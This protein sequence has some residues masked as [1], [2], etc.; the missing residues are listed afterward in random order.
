MNDWQVNVMKYLEN[1]P[2]TA[3]FLGLFLFSCLFAY[4]NLTIKAVFVI[5][6]VL[7]IMLTALKVIRLR[8]SLRVLTI[9]VMSTVIISGVI[10]ALCFDIIG[11]VCENTV[12][13]TETAVI[14]IEEVEYAVSYEACY[15]AKIRKSDSIPRGTGLLLVSDKTALAEGTVLA[16]EVSYSEIE[17]LGRFDAERYYLSKN[18][19]LRA[20]DVSLEPA[21]E[22]RSFSLTRLFAKINESLTAKISAHVRYDAAGIASA[23]LLGN[24]DELADSTV[25]DFRRLGISHLLVVSGT[26][27]AVI[28]TFAERAM[29]YLLVKRKAR[30]W[31]NIAIVILFMFLTGFTPSV[32]R[33]GIMHI[34]A[35]LAN[36]ILRKKNMIHSFAVSG[37]VLVIA[38]PCSAVDCGMQLSFIATYVCIFFQQNHGF[39][40]RWLRKTKLKLRTIPG[41][42]VLSLGETVMLTSL[43][44]LNTLPLMWLYFGEISLISVPVNVVFIPVIT[45]LMYLTG[46]YLLLYPLMIFVQPMA[47]VLSGYCIF[48]EWLA[49]IFSRLDWIILPVNFSFSGLFLIPLTVLLVLLP[50]MG[51][52]PR[53]SI[54]AA[55]AVLFVSFVSAIGLA[56]VLDS[57]NNHFSYLPDK[58]N[59]GFALKSG[60]KVLLC[61][62]S[63]AS[64]SYMYNLTDEMSQLHASEIEALMLTHYHSKHVGLIEKL[65]QRE[66]LRSV[67]LPEPIDEREEGI[68]SSILESAELF[69]VNTVTI[70]AG[71]SYVFGDA[72]IT[73]FERTYLSR[74]SHPI[75]AVEIDINGETAVIASC[76][77]N[78]SV[79]EI[80]EALENAEYPIFGRHSPVYKKAFDLDLR[81]AKAVIVS[82]NAADWIS[83]DAISSAGSEVYLQPD[84]FR[85]R[86]SRKNAK[87]QVSV[88]DE[89]ES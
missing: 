14:E 60:G 31:I 59:D 85:L 23:V 44:T 40:R 47:F 88:S 30:C 70:P 24:R 21:G 8:P 28:V 52:K 32:V 51:K 11:R 73:Q 41:R 49:G 84:A 5:L 83:D 45:V 63:D 6:A 15:K 58:G 77:F 54:L 66:I 1:F 48:I 64:Y 19:R 26:H 78:Q 55:S 36:L 34:L 38:D 9:T 42:I 71:E 82:E 33:A 62:M 16:G 57:F 22:K 3:F 10:S 74:S 89:T 72:V 20:E 25:R 37:A 76:S 87:F 67:I 81:D 65:A 69:G 68:Y 80:T 27:F 46:L 13:K 18:I 39:W 35:Q 4:L 53:K 50:V 29:R 56:L 79:P 75:T 17:N 86:L 12:G 61:E 43:I 7:L 2:Q